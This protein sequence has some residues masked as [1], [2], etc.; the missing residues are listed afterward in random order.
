MF[1]SR[2]GIC[3]G[4]LERT[5]REIDKALDEAKAAG[6]RWKEEVE[7]RGKRRD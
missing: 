7:E 5:G 2:R 4:V 1:T 3:G 6:E